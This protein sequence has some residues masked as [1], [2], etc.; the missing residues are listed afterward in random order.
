MVII[1]AANQYRKTGHSRCRVAVW[2]GKLLPG[3]MRSYRQ[4]CGYGRPGVFLS[5][6]VRK[7]WNISA[8]CICRTDKFVRKGRKLMSHHQITQGN[9]VTTFARYVS[10]NILGMIG[11]SLY[12]L[13]DTF[14]VANGVGSTGLVALNIAIP[15]Y[16]LISGL[17]MLIGMGGGTLFSIAY[18]RGDT[19]SFDRIFTQTLTVTI[20][21][22]AVITLV[23]LC[24]TREIALLLGATPSTLAYVVEYIRVILTFTVAFMLNNV[25]LYFVRNDF[26]PGLAM[27][28]M[29]AGSLFNIVFDY[30]FIYP[31]DMGMFGAAL[32]TGC[33]PVVG[34]CILSF[35][36]WRKK[37]HFRLARCSF[38][39][40]EI[41]RTLSTGLPAFIT[42]FSSGV[43]I[44][45]FNMVILGISDELSV[46]AYG[47]I[48][49]V[50]LVCVAV[51][52][53]IGQGIQPVL[54]VNF[55]S[56][57]QDRVKKVLLMGC[58]TALVFGGLFLLSGL[59]FPETIANIFNGENNPEL[60]RITVQGIRIYFFAFLLMGVNI[61]FSIFFS[62]VGRPR[63]SF[64]IAILRGI[65]AMIPFLV[66]LPP[67]LGLTGVWLVI[68][69]AE[70][71][72]LA[73]GAVL[74]LRTLK[75]MK[76]D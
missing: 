66:I 7:S 45:L 21:I 44:F 51:F 33:S 12:V 31:M 53:G 62:A 43:V 24:F 36:F 1:V 32:A 70:L 68:P 26:E 18:G 41:L 19:S 38:S 16:S 13:A 69:L 55:G 67:L 59:L 60:T 50:A 27:A 3:N 61:V 39:G 64:C 71:T 25:M 74:L 54:S 65:L 34:L 56:G 6:C 17:G 40:S 2:A 30:I 52:T 15:L 48:A 23:G 63:P 72:T 35:H 28:A 49:N 47:I 58:I 46:A 57:K 20:V 9:I 4:A 22:G 10:V 29:L 76:A 75:Q 37:N 5:N 11:L 14:F 73:V 8:L 42:E